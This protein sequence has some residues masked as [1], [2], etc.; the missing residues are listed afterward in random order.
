[1]IITTDKQ[2]RPRDEHDYY[3]TPAWVIRAALDG[4]PDDFQ[5]HRILDPG[6]G[7]G[8]WG[9]EAKLAYWHYAYIAG[10]EE[11]PV[12]S[13]IYYNGWHETDYRLWA[14]DE[15]QFDLIMGNP[16]YKHA[17]EF[18]R[19]S[20]PMLQPGGQMVFLLPLAYL[21][22]QARGRDL[23]RKYPPYKILV[24]STRPSF[25]GDG[26]TDRAEYALFYWQQGWRGKM[27]LDWIHA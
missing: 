23:W 15:Q 8:S 26:N 18:I 20:L 12:P 21:A 1:M 7:D 27:T 2:M 5:P 17:E 24:C 13:C 6:A 25:T 9:R 19:S 22:G 10:V 4:L 3:P 11:R 14:N 16:P